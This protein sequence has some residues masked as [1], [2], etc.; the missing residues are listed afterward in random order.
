MAKGALFIGWGAAARGREQAS[1][2]V[3]N[4]GVQYWTRLRQEGSIDSFE[5]VQLDPHG[6]DLAGFC[7]MKGEAEKL[8]Q[9]R[10]SEEWLRL[11]ARAGMVVDNLGVVTAHVGE[12]LERLFGQFGEA[13][14]DLGG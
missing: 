14:A 11:N 5:A 6:G 9:L 12:G 8:D 13:A 7:L 3:F 10:R 1:L 2:A 4:E